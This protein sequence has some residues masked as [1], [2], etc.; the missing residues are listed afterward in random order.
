METTHEGPPA[1]LTIARA[2]D[3]RRRFEVRC[4]FRATGFES[5]IEGIPDGTQ[6]IMAGL[7]HRD[8]CGRCDVSSVLDRG[9]QADGPSLD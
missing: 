1:S 5:H 7:A 4:P 3:G 2:P 6:I 8:N 9:D